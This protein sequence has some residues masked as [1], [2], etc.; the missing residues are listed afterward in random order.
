MFNSIRKSAASENVKLTP[1]LPNV[2][3]G[4]DMK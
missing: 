4:G 3:S 1:F 2:I